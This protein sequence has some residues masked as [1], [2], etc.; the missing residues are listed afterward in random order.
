MPDGPRGRVDQ[1]FEHSAE[2]PLACDCRS[3]PIGNDGEGGRSGDHAGGRDHPLHG[4]VVG[5]DAIAGHR[6]GKGVDVESVDVETGGRGEV[7]CRHDVDGTDPGRKALA[8]IPAHDHQL[9]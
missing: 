1:S 4:V 7:V 5:V 2:G 3:G 9:R 8:M 6:V